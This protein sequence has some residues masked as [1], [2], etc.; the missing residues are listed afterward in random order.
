LSGKNWLR[1]VKSGVNTAATVAMKS[2]LNRAHDDAGAF[3]QNEPNFSLSQLREVMPTA[4]ASWEARS[5]MLVQQKLA[6]LAEVVARMT[7]LKGLHEAT[8]TRP[9]RRDPQHNIMPEV[10]QILRRSAVLGA[11]SV[12]ISFPNKRRFRRAHAG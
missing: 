9:R 11:A 8:L 1:F 12:G 3:L 4:S 7:Q 5:A 6:G 2:R 10:A